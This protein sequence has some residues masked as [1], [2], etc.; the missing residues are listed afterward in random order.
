MICFR[1]LSGIVFAVDIFWK[2]LV[3]GPRHFFSC[4]AQTRI[5]TNP[6]TF[7]RSGGGQEGGKG[8][9]RQGGE[10]GRDRTHIYI[11]NMVTKL[12][13]Q[14]W[15]CA[16]IAF[17]VRLIWR[18]PLLRKGGVHKYLL[19]GLKMRFSQSVR[20]SHVGGTRWRRNLLQRGRADGA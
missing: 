5:Y 8:K 4:G 15:K 7:T 10:G 9:G 20:Y 12:Q 16:R 11:T 18:R 1:V 17:K 6:N 2:T 19:G 3:T 13:P 14:I